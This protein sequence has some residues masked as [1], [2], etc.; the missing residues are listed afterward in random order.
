MISHSLRCVFIHIPKCGGTSIEDVLWPGPRTTNELWGG[1]V[2]AYCNPYQTGGLQHLTAALVRKVIGEE[3]FER[4]YRFAVVRNP[5][6]RAV[7]QFVFLRR[8]PDLQAFL[9]IDGDAT[10]KAYLRAIRA[11]AHVQ[12]EPQYRFLYDT[13]DRILVDDVLRFEQ[14]DA[15]IAQVFD[16]LGVLGP[17]PHR[18]AGERESLQAYYD[19]E[20]RELVAEWYAQDVHRFGYTFPQVQNA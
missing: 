20:A 4:Y 8:R 6:D 3:T 10:F 5:W 15:S 9:G 13:N 11:R 7:S 14:L 16:R 2:D 1:F 19:D 18:N 17:L 12:W